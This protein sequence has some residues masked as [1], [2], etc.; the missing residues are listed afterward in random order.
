MLIAVL[1]TIIGKRMC[2]ALSMFLGYLLG[3]LEIEAALLIL[4][5]I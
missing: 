5:L 2:K 1:Y 3:K 4:R